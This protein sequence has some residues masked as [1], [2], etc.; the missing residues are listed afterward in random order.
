MQAASSTISIPESYTTPS[1][2]QIRISNHPDSATGVTP[3]LVATLNR[4]DKLNAYTGEMILGL[5]AFFR[6]VTHDDRVKVVILTGAGRAFSAGIDL[7]TDQMVP[8]N[9]P[10]S[11]IRDIGGRLA[12]AMFNCSKTVV[13]AYNG[14]AVGIG[15]T[16]TLAAAVR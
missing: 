2:S 11:E 16:S 14:L 9:L 4:P 5:E 13:V 3:I 15:M 7:T 6:T 12:L 1:T 10:A 8:E